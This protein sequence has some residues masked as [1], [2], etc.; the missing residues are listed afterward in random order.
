MENFSPDDSL[1]VIR[2]MI[3]KTKTEMS[4][5]AVHFLV[6]GWLTFAACIG[7]FVLKHWVGYDKHYLVWSIMVIGIVFSN[8]M[9]F[10]EQKSQ[11]VS[12]Y[13]GDSMLSLWLGMGVSY[14]VLSV[15]FTV[16][17]WGHH[18]FPFF[19]LLYALG[20]FVSGSI[21]R[22][23][24]LIWGGIIAWGLA[25]VAVFLEYDYQILMAAL[26]IL[27]SYIIPA[28]LLQAKKI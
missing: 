6:W 26:A 13:V 19:I 3:D 20:T 16:I 17:G 2:T 7:Q 1:R 15:L 21:L 10:R 8:I 22:F 27:I 28:H 14:F 25:I 5:K 12:T 9:Y 4:G 18:V 24:P 23:H 11:R